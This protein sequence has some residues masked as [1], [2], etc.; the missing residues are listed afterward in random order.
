M[1]TVY[2][3]LT[4]IFA[5]KCS[6]KYF[7]IYSG[8]VRHKARRGIYSSWGFPKFSVSSGN[9]SC[10]ALPEPRALTSPPQA[11]VAM[12]YAVLAPHTLSFTFTHPTPHPQTGFLCVEM[13]ILNSVDH[14]WH[15]AFQVLELKACA[16][17][18]SY[19]V[20]TFCLFVSNS[21][22]YLEFGV[23]GLSSSCKLRRKTAVDVVGSIGYLEPDR[24]NA[25]ICH[26]PNPTAVTCKP[27]KTTGRWPKVFQPPA[28]TYTEPAFPL[29][30]VLSFSMP[31]TVLCR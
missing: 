16:T 5:L 2:F 31:A 30:P 10:A 21:G 18:P 19:E 23:Q 4:D 13:A 3:G 12:I 25:Y 22:A 1:F 8:L 9:P 20:F 7:R 28:G 15:H 26:S 24:T 29:K 11:Y 14:G 27:S 17:L 6:R